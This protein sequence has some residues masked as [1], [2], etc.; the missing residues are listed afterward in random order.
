MLPQFQAERFEERWSTR[1]ASIDS[2][3]ILK[4]I[5]LAAIPERYR[6]VGIKA[7]MRAAPDEMLLPSGSVE[8]DSDSVG[9]SR[10]ANAEHEAHKKLRVTGYSIL[11][12]YDVIVEW[13]AYDVRWNLAPSDDQFAQLSAKAKFPSLKR[14][15]QTEVLQ[16]RLLDC[17]GFLH[18]DKNKRFGFVYSLGPEAMQ[19]SLSFPA[20]ITLH[21]Y[22][23]ATSNYA[24]PSTADQ[25]KRPFLGDIFLLAKALASTLF[26]LHEVGW[27]HKAIS[28]HNILLFCK[29]TTKPSNL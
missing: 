21:Q 15:P 26:N 11:D 4:K 22:I 3:D 5:K 1:V 23:Y 19:H 2:A 12:N 17:L 25:F 10:L 24:S 16:K 27:L 20:L 29:A 7:A 28:S 6:N 13:T 8:F 18:D 9:E 14:T